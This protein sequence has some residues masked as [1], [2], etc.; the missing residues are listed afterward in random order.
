MTEDE[1]RDARLVQRYLPGVNPYEPGRGIFH[2]SDGP[3]WPAAMRKQAE[4]LERAV[5]ALRRMADWL[6]ARQSRDEVE[7]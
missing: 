4:A 2:W 6:E 5:P 1:A 3:Y 7:L